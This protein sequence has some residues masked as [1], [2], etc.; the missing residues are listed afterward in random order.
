MCVHQFTEL[1][2]K[3]NSL[4]NE[5]VLYLTSIHGRRRLRL[6]ARAVDASWWGAS[7]LHPERLVDTLKVRATLLPMP[8]VLVVGAIVVVVTPQR[9]VEGPVIVGTSAGSRTVAL[10]AAPLIT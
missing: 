6:R 7:P 5:E 4:S 9:Q 1:A 10:V 2:L 3:S 8:C